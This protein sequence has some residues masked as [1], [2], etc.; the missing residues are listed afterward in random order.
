[1]LFRAFALLGLLVGGLH[2]PKANAHFNGYF[3][4]RS[5]FYHYARS[6]LV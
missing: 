5:S 4:Q 3:M 1:M 6:N 2:V